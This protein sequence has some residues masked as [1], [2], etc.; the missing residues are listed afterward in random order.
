MSRRVRH[1]RPPGRVPATSGQPGGGAGR[2]P[3]DRAFPGGDRLAAAAATF[4][5]RQ[6]AGQFIIGAQVDDVIG[7]LAHLWED[8]FANTLDLL[9]E[10]T[11]TNADADRRATGW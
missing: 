3:P 10:K 5:I 7:R 8:G 4:G 6:M 11:V 1:R 9:G 2:A